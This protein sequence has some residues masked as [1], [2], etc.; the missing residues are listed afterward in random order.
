MIK[1]IKAL[2]SSGVIL[3]PLVLLGIVTAVY[4]MINMDAEQIY[5][6]FRDYHLYALVALISFVHVFLFKKVYQDDCVSLDYPAMFLAVLAGI[7]RFVLAC[8][9]TISFIVMI[10]F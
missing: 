10:N 5:A 8:G 6:L 1:G 3:N 9:L 7:A 4:C 2:F